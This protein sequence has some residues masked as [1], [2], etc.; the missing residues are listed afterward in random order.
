ME[1]KIKTAYEL[2]QEIN[3]NGLKGKVVRI[4]IIVHSE[5]KQDVEYILDNGGKIVIGFKKP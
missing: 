3:E 4:D 1:I 2:G 5:D